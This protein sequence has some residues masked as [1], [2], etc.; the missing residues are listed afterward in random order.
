MNPLQQHIERQHELAAEIKATVWH[1]KAVPE[2]ESLNPTEHDLLKLC[3]AA[4]ELATLCE[5]Y[6]YVWLTAAQFEAIAA[7]QLSPRYDN[8]DLVIG[9]TEDPD[10][11]SLSYVVDGSGG[12]F[13]T[14]GE[15]TGAVS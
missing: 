8:S 5:G 13:N 11:I 14:K 3:K 4:E 9:H 2:G 12:D 10:T 7:D 1:I 15:C 6:P